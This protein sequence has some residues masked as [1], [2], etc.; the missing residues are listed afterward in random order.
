MGT[1]IIPQ[2]PSAVE[3]PSPSAEWVRPSDWVTLPTLVSTDNRMVG[4]VAVY[5]GEENLMAFT[6]AGAYL[7]LY[8]TS[9]L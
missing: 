5:D 8:L 7:R 9:R 6:A 3:T 2:K 4:I 1:T